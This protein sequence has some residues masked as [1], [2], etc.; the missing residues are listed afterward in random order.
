MSDDPI[1]YIYAVIKGERLG[2]ITKMY[3]PCAFL[4]KANN[5]MAAARMDDIGISPQMVANCHD[6]LEAA[7]RTGIE[8][9]NPAPDSRSYKVYPN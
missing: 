4:L 8:Y 1:L 6:W 5:M 2:S 7:E 3:A 9:H